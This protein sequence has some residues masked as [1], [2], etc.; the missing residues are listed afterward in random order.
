MHFIIEFSNGIVQL[1]I[2]CVYVSLC[3]C[4]CETK[5]LCFNVF[6]SMLGLG[7]MAENCIT[8]SVFYISRYR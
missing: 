7:D 4:V 3:V 5:N 6:V 2:V 1:G 8:I